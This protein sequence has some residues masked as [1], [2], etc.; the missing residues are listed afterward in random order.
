[1]GIVLGPNRYGKAESRVVG[2]VRDTERHQIR[3]LNVS[4][5]LY[6]DFTAAHTDGDQSHVLPTDTQKNTVYAFARDGLLPAAL[7]RLHP[8]F[9]TPWLAIHANVGLVWAL[10]SAG[11]FSTL[12]LLSNV[13]VL[14]A[15]LLCCLAAIELQRRNVQADGRP[16]V[17]PGGPLV[18]LLA[19]VVTLW[20]LSSAT[21]PELAM[22]AGA[23]A[24][25]ALLFAWRAM[26]TR[27]PVADAA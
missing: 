18:P 26:R 3:D 11:T 24:V 7:A 6:G 22:T 21:L 13:A 10:A 9:H 17:L 23:V 14:S 27:A 2:I 4:T 1:M 25:A 5:A 15:Y 20:L 8:R 16:F 12:L 19:C